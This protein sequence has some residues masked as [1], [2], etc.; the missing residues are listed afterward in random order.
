MKAEP[1]DPQGGDPA[2]GGAPEQLNRSA[3]RAASLLLAVGEHP[4]GVSA[5]EL[6][7]EAG[8]PRPTVFRILL[9]LAHTGLLARDGGRFSLG[10]KAAHLGRLADPHR[11]ILSKIQ[12]IVEALAE[13]FDESVAYSA[14]T[15]RTGQEVIAEAEG[16]RLLAPSRRYI[17]REFPLHASATGK[18]MLAHL[19]EGEAEEILPERLEALTSRTITDRDALRREL[20]AIRDQ[21]FVTL[22]GE[23]EEG[24]YAVAVPVRDGAGRLAGV[25]AVSGLDQR[26]KTRSVDAYVRG[27]RGAADRLAGLLGSR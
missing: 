16:S 10:W 18:L 22:D 12:A 25:L 24:L 6:A 5:A 4:E 26:M 20:A 11:G 17:G 2:D 7:A 8:I 15:G 9:S 1:L 19:P 23:L 27:L 21:G 13:E 14:V 3:L